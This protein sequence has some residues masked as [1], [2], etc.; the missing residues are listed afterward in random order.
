M[1]A[2][3]LGG[4]QRSIRGP[5]GIGRTAHNPAEVEQNPAEQKGP[6]AQRIQKRKG[7][8]ART[9]LQRNYRVHQCEDHRHDAKKDHGRAVHG[10]QFVEGLGI[11][12]GIHRLDQLDTD[13][14]GLKS[15][16]A[17]KQA[18][19][20]QVQN[21]NLFMIDGGNPVHQSGMAF[22]AVAMSQRR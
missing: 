4:G 2:A 8:I 9:D 17:K 21:R 12:K 11:Q 10:D 20:P 15:A 22:H 14:N 7:D 5:A 19:S 6:E 3:V 1:C 18:S 16:D 13:Q